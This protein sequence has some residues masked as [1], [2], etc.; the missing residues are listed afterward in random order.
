MDGENEREARGVSTRLIVKRRDESRSLE[1]HR[2]H[3]R[4]VKKG[5]AEAG[6]DDFSRRE[7]SRHIH[8][9]RPSASTEWEQS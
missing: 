8:E 2:S 4:S 7:L 9:C 6:A 1:A 5:N 3:M